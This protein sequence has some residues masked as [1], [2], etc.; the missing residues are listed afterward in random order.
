MFAA[1]AGNERS[2]KKAQSSL[3]AGAGG[4]QFEE[5]TLGKGYVL[6]DKMDLQ[7]NTY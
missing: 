4:K 2:D 7:R 1:N 5:Q 6:I 3:V